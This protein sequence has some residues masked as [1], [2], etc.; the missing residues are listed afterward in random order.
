M[1]A[2]TINAVEQGWAG[3]RKRHLVSLTVTTTNADT[4]APAA[5]GLKVIEAIVPT[6][7]V[8]TFKI[9]GKTCTFT[10]HGTGPKF[11]VAANTVTVTVQTAT[12]LA[13]HIYG[14]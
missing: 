1:A 6:G 12:T 9:A 3:D 14:W 10:D 2:A 13:V 8:G 5:V 4:I 7:M 11:A